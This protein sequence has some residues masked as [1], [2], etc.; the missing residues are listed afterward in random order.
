MSKN[1]SSKVIGYYDPEEGDIYCLRHGRNY[2][3]P[4][5][6]HD[7]DYFGPCNICGELIDS[8]NSESDQ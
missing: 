4:I 5:L 7:E 1:T 8:G 6:E 2:M 3:L